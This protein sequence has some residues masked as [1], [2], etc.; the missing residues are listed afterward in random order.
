MADS[1]IRVKL[2]DLVAD[3]SAFQ[4]AT[5]ASGSDDR[6]HYGWP[7][8]TPDLPADWSRGVPQLSSTKPAYVTYHV[9]AQAPAAQ[10]IGQQSDP[11]VLVI[12]DIWARALSDLESVHEAMRDALDDQCALTTTSF[13]IQRI[14]EDGAMDLGLDYDGTNRRWVHRRQVRYLAEGIIR[15]A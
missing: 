5:G 7:M 10:K 6:L 14:S 11:D 15:L 2:H 1:E 4:T 3:D 12:F 13:R 8:D 9:E